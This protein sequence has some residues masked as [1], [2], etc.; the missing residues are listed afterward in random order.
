MLNIQEIKKSYLVYS[1]ASLSITLLSSP[2][3][4]ATMTYDLKIFTEGTNTQVG[5]G[6]FTTNQLM[7]QILSVDVNIDAKTFNEGFFFPNPPNSNSLVF[8]NQSTPENIFSLFGAVPIS[9][10]PEP[11]GMLIGLARLTM[12]DMS[13]DFDYKLTKT[14]PEPTS[15]LSI[16]SLGIL[17]AGATL[18]RKVK[19]SH[20]IEKETTKVG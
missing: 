12:G 20:C 3:I 13:T 10:P 6:N 4:A 15:T 2:A 18:K 14:T 5:G 7:D 17:G 1:I 19:R 11:G 8:V 16:L 9:L